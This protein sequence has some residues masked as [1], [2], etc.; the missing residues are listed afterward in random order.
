MNM[1]IDKQALKQ[2]WVEALRSGEY[3]Q[4][5]GA[6]RNGDKFCCLGVLCDILTD[7][8]REELGVEWVVRTYPRIDLAVGEVGAPDGLGGKIRSTSMLPEQLTARLGLDFDAAVR[9]ASMNDGDLDGNHRKFGFK[10]IASY[11]ES[12]KTLFK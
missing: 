4:G 3:E 2:R 9:L 5:A 6:L 8:E 12:R 10:A 7:E 11:I 1:T